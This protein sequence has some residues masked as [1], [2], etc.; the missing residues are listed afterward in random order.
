MVTEFP[1]RT[2]G[3]YKVEAYGASTLV[4]ITAVLDSTRKGV[5]QIGLTSA[6]QFAKDFPL[7]L[8]S[9][10][11][12]YGW[13]GFSPTGMETPEIL[14]VANEAFL[15]FQKIPEV[16]AEYKD[17][18]FLSNIVLNESNIVMKSKPV[19]VPADF[20]GVKFGATGPTAEIVKANGGAAVA[21]VTPEVYM[22]MDKGVIEGAVL[23]MTMVTDWKIQTIANWFL[24]IGTGNGNMLSLMNQEFW[25]KMPKADQDLL[26]KTWWDG[27]KE[28][29]KFM[30]NSAIVSRDIM[31]KDGKT[32]T[33]PTAAEKAAWGKGVEP[34]YR[35]MR[36]DAVS[37]GIDSKTFD[38]VA[39]AW[40]AIRDKYAAKYNLK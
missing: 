9:Q 30:A 38:K 21:L 34:A 5:A 1:K 17:F 32:M 25:N 29:S 20:R 28:N 31:V 14:D 15:E 36:D 33:I 39:E 37:V 3:R 7:T 18:V 8:I 16:A 4:P 35:G 11:P 12:T 23:S 22:N 13:A 27:M 2:D 26:Y 19:R 10:M 24:M 40:L 6:N